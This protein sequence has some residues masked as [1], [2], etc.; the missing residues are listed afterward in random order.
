MQDHHS[1]YNR[2]AGNALRARENCKSKK[3]KKLWLKIY[4]ALEERRQ[5]TI[6]H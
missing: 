3:F 4:R 1:K 2:L 5:T 6:L